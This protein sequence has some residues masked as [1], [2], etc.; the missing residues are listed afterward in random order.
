[1]D[2]A[3]MLDRDLLLPLPVG[4]GG[5]SVVFES[6]IAVRESAK[7]LE[8]MAGETAGIPTPVVLRLDDLPAATLFVMQAGPAERCLRLLAEPC[9]HKGRP[10]IRL[11]ADVSAPAVRRRLWTGRASMVASL[12]G[13]GSVAA[14]LW[15]P[16]FALLALGL[17]GALVTRLSSG[18]IFEHDRWR[19]D[20]ALG[21]AAA[22]LLSRFATERSGEFVHRAKIG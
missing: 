17:G 18:G 19:A 13:L 1:M 14:G 5:A 6:A 15:V 11:R 10:W 3:Q 21:A 7:L 22:A 20:P 2:M 16:A 4:A 12:A 9:V 8:R